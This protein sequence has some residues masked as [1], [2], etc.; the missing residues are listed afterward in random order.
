MGLSMKV[1]CL[2][3]KTLWLLV[4]LVFILSTSDS[5]PS[6]IASSDA[7]DA[8][9]LFV[10]D[11]LLRGA[12]PSEMTGKVGEGR[13]TDE[14]SGNTD[15]TINDQLLKFKNVPQKLWQTWP[16]GAPRFEIDAATGKTQKVDWK[17]K[18]AKKKAKGSRKKAAKRA[19]M[20]ALSCSEKDELVRLGLVQSGTC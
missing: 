15:T 17:A 3:T 5:A 7:D 13:R 14:S 16:L 18:R 8:A 9:N 19:K 20:K 12:P 10:S 6:P 1:P 2:A 4:L 11:K